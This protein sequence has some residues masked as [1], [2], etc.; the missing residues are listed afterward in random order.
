VDVL[1]FHEA[2][3]DIVALFQH[4]SFPEVLRH[5]IA[6]TSGDLTRENLLG[7]LAQQFGQA[8]GR[9]GALRDAIGGWD[10]A[11]QQWKLKEPK[12]VDIQKTLEPHDRGAILV[13]AVFEAFLDV[14][15]KR[16][17][18]LLRIATGGTGKLPE[19]HIHPDLVERMAQEAAGTASHIQQMCIRAV[20]YCP[21][22]DI[23]F[24]EFLRALI[25]ADENLVPEDTFGYR[26][27]MIDAFR[28]RG[29]FPLDVRNLAA[30]SL[31]WQEPTRREQ[32]LLADFING[33]ILDPAGRDRLEST[34]WDLYSDRQQVY[35]QMRDYRY[36]VHRWFQKRQNPKI[37]S[38]M[39]LAIGDNAPRTI[40]RK[41]G[42]PLVEV[43]SIRP[44]RRSSPDGQQMTELVVEITQRR[45][46]FLDP[47]QQKAADKGTKF[48]TERD[49][50][51][52]GGCT[53]LV[54][55]Q[56]GFVRYSIRKDI[57]S[58]NRLERQRSFLNAPDGS[59][60][61]TYFGNPKLQTLVEPFA[62]V[63]RGFFEGDSQ[64][65]P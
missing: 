52:R 61:T 2:F 33:A 38:L 3:A 15:K 20:D 19:G 30:D 4:F 42:L 13:S 48:P 40:S 50:W 24:G 39:G 44:A 47:Q 36:H 49:F 5:Q 64:W 45:R 26:A 58:N 60:R 8:I 11:S 28:R 37:G 6:L 23:T 46:A 43:H 12:A 31:R 25:T 18:D 51:F 56:T 22:V 55:P 16:I 14:Y 10:K 34:R 32:E 59:L 54:D 35:D 7:Q 65:A 21:P 53:L 29:I 57:T 9:Y 27:A 41:N 1:A 62:C 17:E 63:H